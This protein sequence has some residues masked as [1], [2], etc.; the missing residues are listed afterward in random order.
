M[1]WVKLFSHGSDASPRDG[2]LAPRAQGSTSCVVMY[3]AVRLTIVFEVAT[4]RKGHQALAAAETLVMPLTL[5][6]RNVIGRDR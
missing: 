6:S 1:L 5:E 4:A 3:F 2:L